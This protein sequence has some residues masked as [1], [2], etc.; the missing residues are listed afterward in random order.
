MKQFCPVHTTKYTRPLLFRLELRLKAIHL[1]AAKSLTLA[2]EIQFGKSVAHSKDFHRVDARAG[3]A[4]L[5]E[6][7]EIPV[8]VPYD[9]RK[10]QFSPKSVTI[11]VLEKQA[12]LSK[13]LG[14]ATLAVSAILNEKI[15][16][17]RE[18]LKLEKC[19]DKSAVLKLTAE[20]EYRG[21][22]PED[23]SVDKSYFSV[24]HSSPDL[25]EEHRDLPKFLLG[26]ANRARSIDGRSR[27]NLG[28]SRAVRLNRSIDC[29]SD[30]SRSRHLASFDKRISGREVNTFRLRVNESLGDPYKAQRLDRIKGRFRGS[31]GKNYTAANNR[32]KK[33]EL[34]PSDATPP[35]SALKEDSRVMEPPRDV[36]AIELRLDN[37]HD[38]ELGVKQRGQ[39]TGSH[40]RS[41]YEVYD[42]R[43]EPLAPRKDSHARKSDSLTVPTKNTAVSD[44]QVGFSSDRADD[45]RKSE[46]Q[47]TQAIARQPKLDFKSDKNIKAY[48]YRED[49]DRSVSEHDFKRN[50][51]TDFQ[52]SDM[53][54][55]FGNFR[56]EKSPAFVDRR[57]EQAQ[58][59]LSFRPRTGEDG[60]EPKANRDNAILEFNDAAPHRPKFSVDGSNAFSYGKPGKT[61]LTNDYSPDREQE[62]TNSKPVRPQKNH[63]LDK[64]TKSSDY[65]LQATN[66]NVV[67][68]K[69]P[70]PE[71]PKPKPVTLTDD[72]PGLPTQRARPAFQQTEARRVLNQRA[73]NTAISVTRS[74]LSNFKRPTANKQAKNFDFT[75]KRKDNARE[76]DA[77]K[78]LAEAEET[79]RAL[80]EDLFRRDA[81]VAALNNSMRDDKLR[82]EALKDEL[83]KARAENVNAVSSNRK[84]VDRIEELNSQ[85][86]AA[87][88]RLQT[89]SDKFGKMIDFIYRAN[90]PQYL[91]VLEDIVGNKGRNDLDDVYK[92]YEALK[93]R[94]A[95]VTDLM[96]MSRDRT[97]IDKLEEINKNK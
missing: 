55:Q 41:N 93:R 85:L 87:R 89:T 24:N 6:T 73:F 15:M 34:S 58:Q 81:E 21:N 36:S 4:K 68:R 11:H 96:Y 91:A 67:Q 29:R 3:Q 13:K 74:I 22:A 79:V 62:A 86:D 80:K 95:D 18:T 83:A 69:Q 66:T 19:D 64:S 76:L 61:P 1:R 31:E 33:N 10:D 88:L 45:R 2:F 84:A 51:E 65:E 30:R 47:S 94:M 20:L 37:E 8:V 12:K 52:P 77:A 9:P 44:P 42:A 27:S 59:I 70:E 60:A 54:Q 90:N 35:L 48:E 72:A 82:I 23:D 5:S 43:F 39:E 78:N 32:A 53:N 16:L 92:K 49:R 97:L 50:L 40:A 7:I 71:Q 26:G 57:P 28:D 38:N 75:Q 56:V 17:S 25:K 46:A 63:I 14:S